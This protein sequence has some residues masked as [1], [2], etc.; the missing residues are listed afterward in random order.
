MDDIRNLRNKFLGLTD[1]YTAPD[2]PITTE[3]KQE[4]F[5]YRQSLRD[6]PQNLPELLDNN[7]LNYFPEKPSFVNLCPFS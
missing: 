6:L 5:A 1:K 3:Q 2:F 7:I 4:L